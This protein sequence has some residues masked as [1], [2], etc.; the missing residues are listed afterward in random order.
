MRPEGVRTRFEESAVD[1]MKHR[2]LTEEEGETRGRAHRRSRIPRFRVLSNTQKR[3]IGGGVPAASAPSA[4]SRERPRKFPR[5][6]DPFR[7]ER[8]GGAPQQAEDRLE[9]RV[10][11]RLDL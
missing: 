5:S 1:S 9:H 4:P 2:S 8:D 11:P 7:Q 6:T 10:V 3:A